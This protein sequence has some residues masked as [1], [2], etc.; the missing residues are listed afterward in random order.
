MDE[1]DEPL[2]GDTDR[3]VP[4]AAAVEE[5]AGLGSLPGRGEDV[6]QFLGESYPAVRRYADLL[7]EQGVLRGLIGPRELPR[8]W[9]RHLLNS[10]AV[11]R[12]LPSAGVVV[13]VGSGAG[14]PGVVLAAMRPDLETVLVEPMERR[15]A[16]LTEVVSELELPAVRVER[17]RAE[18]LHGR[19][20]ADVVTGRAVAP[21]ARLAG[22]TLPL[23]RQGGS[24]L[25]IKGRQAGVELEDARGRIRSLGG[26][27]GE[28]VDVT[29]IDG[30]EGTHVVRVHRRAEAVPQGA[31][32]VRTRSAARGARR[33][34]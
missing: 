13:D 3:P 16:W 8:L 19:L 14:L 32:G 25:A 33:R 15:V 7:A 6:A 21:L 20:L 17:A 23:L 26:D 2:T 1:R 4:G 12:L 28:V 9:E 34:R 29:T 30:V 22:W 11:A 18:E 10:A 5:P 27:D 24:L 31:P